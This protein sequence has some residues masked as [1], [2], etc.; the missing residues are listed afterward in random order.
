M[1]KVV[2]KKKKKVAASGDGADAKAPAKKKEAPKPF[3]R[4]E[5]F[6]KTKKIQTVIAPIREA[7]VTAEIVRPRM[8]TESVEHGRGQGL[9][10]N[11]TFRK[12]K[13]APKAVVYVNQPRS[14]GGGSFEPTDRLL[15]PGEQI[16]LSFTTTVEG[17]DGPIVFLAKG[18]FLRKSFLIPKN[19]NNDD[20][21]WSGPREEAEKKFGKD[22]M[23]QGDDIIEIRVD[24]INSFPGGP[25]VTDR[26]VL[27]CYLR[28]AKLY[29]IP[30]GGGWNQKSTQGSFFKGIRDPLDKY[31]ER[32]DIKILDKITIHEWVNTGGLG[33]MVSGRLLADVDDEVVRPMVVKKP[34]DFIGE[35]NSKLGFLLRFRIDQ[36][37]AES[38]ARTFAKKA[39]KAD[40]VYLPLILERVEDALEQ[41][42]VTFRV[43]PRDLV[44]DRNPKSMERGL[45]FMPP[46]ALHQG[47][48]NQ[49]TFSKLLIL[50]NQRF[51]ED[52][53]PEEEKLKSAGL[54]ASVEARINERRGAFVDEKVKA[55]FQDRVSAKQRKDEDS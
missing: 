2:K 48:E 10:R 34:N 47:S 53:K 12:F 40:E 43:F 32:E 11:F 7:A 16:R 37:I 8:L 28:E 38:L 31:L 55:A 15:T 14:L 33:I 54:Q 45:Q 36:D 20:K 46:F 50:L 49:A 30:G 39:G 3:S 21:P 17:S 52:E 25:A 29:I 35:I 51:R 24:S 41:F 44:E 19:P 22:L 4:P 27:D 18:F 42:R 6:T 9:M 1:D 26:T 13:E 23:V 5:L